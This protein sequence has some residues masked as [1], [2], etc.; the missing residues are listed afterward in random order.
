MEDKDLLLIGRV[1][2]I[3]VGVG[4]IVFGLEGSDDSFTAFGRWLYSKRSAIRG[5]LPW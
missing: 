3:S 4:A 2:L 5:L 1:A